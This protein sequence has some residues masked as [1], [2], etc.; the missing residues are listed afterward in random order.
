MASGANSSCIAVI[1]WEPGVVEGGAR[2][3]RRGVAGLAGGREPGSRVVRIRSGLVV[4]LVTGE[5]VGWNRCVVIVHVATGARHSRVLSS[6]GEWRVVVI[7]RGRN[8]GRGVV[9]HLA[10]LREA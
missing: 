5:A 8:P 1:G 3:C 9:A 4:A 6:Q 7:K 10:L 2:P